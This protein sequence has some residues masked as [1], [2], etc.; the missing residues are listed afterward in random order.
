M[1]KFENLRCDRA[2]TPSSVHTQS[3]RLIRAIFQILS[4]KASRTPIVYSSQQVALGA[5][6]RINTMAARAGIQG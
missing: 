4:A 1:N 3:T 2:V 5:S 6:S